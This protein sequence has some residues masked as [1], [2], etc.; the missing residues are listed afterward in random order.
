MRID[1]TGDNT[2]DLLECL[3]DYAAAL[4]DHAPAG[5]PAAIEL[6]EHVDGIIAELGRRN[7]N[8]VLTF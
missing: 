3:T 6:R 4:R 5:T 1:W 2:E 8:A 7:I